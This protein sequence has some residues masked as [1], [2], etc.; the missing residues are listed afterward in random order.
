MA[1]YGTGNFRIQITWELD[2]SK[3]TYCY[4]TKDE[5]DKKY[6]FHKASDKVRNVIKI[7]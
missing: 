7:G 3:D 4:G 2:G 6:K 1:H 5:R